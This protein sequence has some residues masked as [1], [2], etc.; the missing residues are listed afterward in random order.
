MELRTS[1][2]CFCW[3]YMRRNFERPDLPQTKSFRLS[4]PTKVTIEVGGQTDLR[5]SF[6]AK[7]LPLKKRLPGLNRQWTKDAESEKQLGS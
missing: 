2:E 3:P 5:Q 1:N 6:P 4:V 7:L